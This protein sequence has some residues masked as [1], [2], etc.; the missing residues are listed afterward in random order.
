M[1]TNAGNDFRKSL[2]VSSNVDTGR[3]TAYSNIENNRN[4]RR[5]GFVNTNTGKIVAYDAR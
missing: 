4:T 5:K 1:Y 3:I 2:R